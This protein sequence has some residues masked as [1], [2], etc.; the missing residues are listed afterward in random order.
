[1]KGIS[2]KSEMFCAVQQKYMSHKCNLKLFNCCKKVKGKKKVKLIL[3]VY[4]MQMYSV[5]SFPNVMFKTY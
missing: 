3:I 5:L 2:T 4:V 1:M